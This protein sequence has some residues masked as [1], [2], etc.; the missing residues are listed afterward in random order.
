MCCSFIHLQMPRGV[1]PQY[2]VTLRRGVLSCLLSVPPIPSRVQCVRPQR[3]RPQGATGFCMVLYLD[4]DVGAA[5]ERFGPTLAAEHLE[6]EDGLK[7]D[8][9]TPRHWMLAER[10]WTTRNKN[11]KGDTSNEVTKRTF[12]TSFDTIRAVVLDT[13]I[14]NV[15]YGSSKWPPGCSKKS[16]LRH[17]LR[18]SQEVVL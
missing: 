8:A 12:L 17:G 13:S 11:Q 18:Q 5:A 15:L 3:R 2:Y 10:L 16:F 6:S 7:I 4:E 14:S 1:C 9:E